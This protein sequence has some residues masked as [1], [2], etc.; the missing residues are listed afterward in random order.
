MIPASARK[1]SLAS[2][3]LGKAAATSGSRT[4][5]ALPAAYRDANL[6]GE[7][8]LKSYSRRISSGST[9]SAGTP[10]LGDLFIIS[11]LW[12]CGLSGADDANR[13]G[14]FGVHDCKQTVLFRPTQQP[15]APLRLNDEDRPPFYPKDRRRPWR[16]PRTIPCASRDFRQP[17]ADPTRTPRPNLIILADQ[18]RRSRSSASFTSTNRRTSLQ[19]DYSREVG[20]SPLVCAAPRHL[21]RTRPHRLGVNCSQ[22]PRNGPWGV[23]AA[24]LVL[25]LTPRRG[26]STSPKNRQK[27]D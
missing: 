11:S 18:G 7:P 6:L 15:T 2:S 1:A 3:E 8:R 5:T 20:L 4:T 27:I 14:A 22:T 26:H 9:R 17:F 19:S 21:A 16:P 13:L 12:T 24:A 23:F 10:L 25:A